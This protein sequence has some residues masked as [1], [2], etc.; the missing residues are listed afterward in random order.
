MPT[1]C[2]SVLLMFVTT[3]VELSNWVFVFSSLILFWRF[4]YEK[5]NIK[6]ITPKQSVLPA[7]ALFVVVYFSYSTLIGQDPAVT[8]L[9]GLASIAILNLET[10]RDFLF[11][12]LLCFI[13]LAL[14]SLFS[15]E[16]YHALPT[17][18][19]F[20]GIFSCLI[21]S[22]KISK[23]RLM[24]KTLVLAMPLFLV[25]FTFFPRWVIFKSNQSSRKI[26]ISGFNEELN[27]GYLS[28]V[29]LSNKTVFRAEFINAHMST[30][31]LYWSGAVLNL[32]EGL[33]WRKSKT[34]APTDIDWGK[35]SVLY[36]MTFEPQP[37]KNLF[38]LDVP[39]EAPKSN[40]AV[41][42]LNGV[43]YVLNEVTN[44]NFQLQAV[45]VTDSNQIL[46]SGDKEKYLQFKKLPIKS[47]EL[48]KN[49]KSN[50]I[51]PIQ[52]LS[53][54]KDFFSNQ[55]FQYTLT[56]D[57]FDQNMDRFLFES[58]KGYC[59]HFAAAFATLSRALDIPA[60]VVVGYQ[61]GQYNELGNYWKISQR[62]AHAWV[63]IA[64]NGNWKRE[65]PTAL[66]SP[67]RLSLGGEAFFDL[68]E[69]EQL[70]YSKMKYLRNF[71]EKNQVL[72]AIFR[73]ADNVNY[74]WTI[75]LL[76]YDMAFQFKILSLVNVKSVL[77]SLFIIVG[78]FITYYFFKK[79]KF[80]KYKF[81]HIRDL[82]NEIMI[83]AQSHSQIFEKNQQR[84]PVQNLILLSKHQEESSSFFKQCA[85]EY[86]QVVYNQSVATKPVK[87]LRKEW[88]QVKK[89]L[90]TR[91]L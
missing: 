48:I 22:R 89:K 42:S 84:G 29:V 54:L 69:E 10:E 33:T 36:K 45:S 27:P 59:E 87:L 50:N 41:H 52:R 90:T 63:E 67:L 43:Q 77:L 72:D 15:V 76:N 14:K 5:M 25:L 82:V 85:E 9:F 60:R 34:A 47:E 31:D 56:P 88:Q 46:N 75:F 68:T 12:C 38:L 4:L 8:L 83:W 71:K 1:F 62:D 24:A 35:N 78:L 91:P 18:V 26:G 74:N 16:L 53:A 79:Y 32:S 7:L 44:K 40:L 70:M 65:D 86:E 6:K 23:F 66:V 51:T 19:S 2:F 55:K 17:L 61:G 30:E 13:I 73:W 20:L 81:D 49:I 11:I 57:D 58:K 3:A 37:N 39:R 21:L 28:Q 80:R 64:L